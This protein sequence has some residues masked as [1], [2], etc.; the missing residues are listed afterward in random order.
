MLHG[1]PVGFYM[2]QLHVAE[3]SSC[4]LLLAPLVPLWCTHPCPASLS[5]KGAEMAGV[6]V[7]DE[8]VENQECAPAG[9]NITRVL[10]CFEGL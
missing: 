8:Q 7:G 2:V 10:Q 9:V 1:G 3:R 6:R 5:R 4:S